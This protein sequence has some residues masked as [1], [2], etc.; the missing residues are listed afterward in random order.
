MRALHTLGLSWC[1]RQKAKACSATREAEEKKTR[2]ETAEP[3]HTADLSM[4]FA[5]D[6]KPLTSIPIL[7]ISSF[8]LSHS[9]PD[10]TRSHRRDD[11]AAAPL[12]ADV[13]ACYIASRGQDGPDW[14]SRAR[15]WSCRLPRLKGGHHLPRRDGGRCCH[16]R[17][18]IWCHEKR[19]LFGNCKGREKG[20]CR[21]NGEARPMTVQTDRVSVPEAL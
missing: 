4:P 1:R 16:W 18:N 9:S 10:S 2:Q 7:F 15:Y 21:M 5:T 3:A 17:S 13:D 11:S 8:L 12:A 20:E 14:R 6:R 19:A